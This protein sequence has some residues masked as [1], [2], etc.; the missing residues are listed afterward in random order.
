MFQLFKLFTLFVL[1]IPS[2]QLFAQTV[3][4]EINMNSTKGKINH[5]AG[6][7]F[8]SGVSNEPGEKRNRTASIDYMASTSFIKN[9]VTTLRI[10]ATSEVSGIERESQ[11]N[12]TFIFNTLNNVYTNEFG[13]LTFNLNTT[14]PT[15]PDTR[16]FESLYT[17]FS[18]GPNW[19]FKTPRHI[20]LRARTNISKGFHE[21]KTGTG[22]RGL[23][24]EYTVSHRLDLSYQ[25]NDLITFSNIFINTHRWNYGGSRTPDVFGMS[26]VIDF[27]L[28][29]KTNL[30]LGHDVS[31]QTFASNG[32][33]SNLQLFNERTSSVYTYLTVRF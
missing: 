3:Q 4:E 10:G 15:N 9:L 7:E 6:V 14:L 28:S 18:G 33:T 16:D 23:N 11:I 29:R 5:I 2:S 30:S 8:R 24:T 26:Q 13:M 27:R 20:F 1:I 22:R 31:D 12:N 32:R 17:R 25:F 21:F 19:I